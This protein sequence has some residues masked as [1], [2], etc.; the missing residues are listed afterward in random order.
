MPSFGA[1]SLLVTQPNSKEVTRNN[2]HGGNL[3]D[4]DHRRMTA[5]IP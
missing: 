1:N 2:P 4:L 5:P 3:F